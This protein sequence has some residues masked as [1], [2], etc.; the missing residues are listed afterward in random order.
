MRDSLYR[1]REDFV[2]RLSIGA[3]PY[4]TD[5]YPLGG[6]RG[7][8]V[9]VELHGVNLHKAALNVKIPQDGPRVMW[10]A[11]TGQGLASNRVKFEA[12]ELNE[13]AKLEPNDTPQQANR[14]SVGSVV[15]GRIGKPGDLDYFVV[16]AAAQQ[17]SCFEVQA[18]RLGSPLDSVIT[19]FDSKGKR[20]GRERR[21]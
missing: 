16:K 14:V 20:L 4:I 2:Y 19:L 6:K 3:L 12:G 9:P 8:T 5:I 15:N 17:K 21:H 13:T 7:T 11:T 1:G 18:R 10:L